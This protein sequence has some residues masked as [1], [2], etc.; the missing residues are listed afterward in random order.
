MLSYS[1]H[2]RLDLFYGSI[3]QKNNSFFLFGERKGL[4]KEKGSTKLEQA[5]DANLICR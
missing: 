4:D 2:M 5:H 3:S 1:F